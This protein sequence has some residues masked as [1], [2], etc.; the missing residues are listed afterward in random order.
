TCMTI[1]G[2]WGFRAGDDNWKSPETLIRNLVDIAS[3]GGNYLL[4]VGPTAEGSIPAPSIERLHAMGAWMKAN[5][6]A[7]Y[8]T[9]A[10]PFKDA[11]PW[12]RVTKKVG[13]QG[14]T[15]YLHVFDWPKDGQLRLPLAA[16]KVKGASLLLGGRKLAVKGGG[17]GVVV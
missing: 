11:L 8:G 2:T 6:E 9:T 10:S 13:K 17:D 14:T 5:G 15:L 4:N 1:N 3:K 12:G 7:I 16:G